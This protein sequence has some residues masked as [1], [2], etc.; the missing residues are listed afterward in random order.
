MMKQKSSPEEQKLRQKD[1]RLRK[2]YGISLEEFNAKLESQGNGCA[3]EGC[4][5]G[6]T[7]EGVLCQDHVHVKGFKKMLP[8]E[9][10]KYLRGIV[11]FMHNTGFKSFEKTIDGV[12]NRA[13]LTGT[14]KYFLEYKLKG[15]I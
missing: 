14:Y 13:S 4:I 15:E 7:K 3:I 1:Q 6:R 8:E 12:R 11:C 5:I 2:T 9:K 10:K